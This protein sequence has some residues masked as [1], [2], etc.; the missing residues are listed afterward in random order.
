LPDEFGGKQAARI[1]AAAAKMAQQYADTA[2]RG[3][4]TFAPRVLRALQRAEYRASSGPHSG[5]ATEHY[6]HFTSPIRRYPELVVHRSLLTLLGL[7]DG[8]VAADGIGAIAEH[9]STV[10]REHQQL[11]RRAER[12]ALAYLLHRRLHAGEALGDDGDGIWSGEVTGMVGGGLFVRFGD[13]F[14]GFVPAR[15][16]AP[17]ERYELDEHGLAMVGTKSGHPIRIGDAI[18]VYVDKVDRSTG[19]IDLRRTRR[20]P[21]GTTYREQPRSPARQRRGAPTAGRRAP[22]GRRRR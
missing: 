4:R 10:E 12:I 22:R 18:E 20:A 1:A 6:A 14:E 8:P 11:E 9:V 15:T 16:L 3:R 17:D 13:V 19:R 5:L 2:R 21:D 7:Y